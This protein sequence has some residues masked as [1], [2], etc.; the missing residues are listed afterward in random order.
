MALKIPFLNLGAARSVEPEVS[1]I[2]REAQQ[3]QSLK[4]TALDTAKQMAADE[5][6]VPNMTDYFRSALS[7]SEQAQEQ[8][9]QWNA[10]VIADISG[11]TLDGFTVRKQ[12]IYPTAEQRADMRDVLPGRAA[13]EATPGAEGVGAQRDL[14]DLDGDQAVSDFY[15][16]V[17][18]QL[19]CDNTKFLNCTFHP[20][21]TLEI[22]DNG[23]GGKFGNVTF[24]GMERGETLTLGSGKHGT[25]E[26][27][28]DVHFT[29]IQGGTIVVNDYATVGNLHL[30]GQ[31]TALEIRG[32]AQVNDLHAN[33][34]HIVHLTAGVGARIERAVFEGATIDMASDL[35]GS[36]WTNAEFKDANLRDVN[37]RGAHLNGAHFQGSD[38]E[39][40]SF[41]GA[42][43]SNVS[44]QDVSLSGVDFAE[45][46]LH[47]VRILSTDPLTG[48]AQ[49]LRVDSAEQLAEIVRRQ[50]SF[51]MAGAIGANVLAPEIASI[52][53][54]EAPVQNLAQ[55]GASLGQEAVQT[56]RIDGP[57]E[58]RDMSRPEPS[59]GIALG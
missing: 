2:D 51:A 58:N 9:L 41:A 52:R 49:N 8:G 42:R 21:T 54:E 37:F 46:Q 4:Q 19:R 25:G 28:H 50:E 11:L 59:Q 13:S 38:M 10:R 55:L 14:Y 29:N 32:R 57:L 7:L 47:N 12:D 31:T 36:V 5:G 56:N 17:Q 44:F 26:V 43:L 48:Q 35:A 1:D 27:F 45:A 53:R 30:E 22:V 20:A 16:E 39:G 40:V 34:A 24:D 33:G 6:R 23:R 3:L 15:T 18:A